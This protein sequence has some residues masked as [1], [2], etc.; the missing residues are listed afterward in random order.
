MRAVRLYAARDLRVEEI[1]APGV[2]APG[3]VRVRVTAAGICGSD[4][5]NFLTG[6]WISRVPSVAGHEFAGVVEA[7]GPGVSAL[8]PGDAVV[9]DS[10]F[11][12]GSCPACR[13]GRANVCERLGFVGEVCD[14]GFAE[15]VA[16]PERLLTLIAPTIDP[17]AAAL[18]EPLAVALHA[19][20]RLAPEPASPVLIAGCGPIGGLAALV[21]SRRH[22]GPVL[23]ADRN[24]ERL[25]R[26]VAVT[27]AHPVALDAEAVA[28]ARAGAPLLAALDA[29]GSS[30]VIETLAGLLAPGGRLALVG[31][32]RGS[33]EIDPTHLVEAE[34]A[35]LGCHA[36]RDE[37]AQAAALL[38]ALEAD[39]LALVD[40]TI[41][42]AEVPAAY[43]RLASGRASGLK[44]IILP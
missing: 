12:C 33:V 28:S 25:A 8:K 26:V 29:T 13:A 40:E 5:H 10:R 27:G 14:G 16:L 44:T 2:P 9:A 31:I 6:A 36:F 19:L 42:L 20:A 23:V 34:I 22:D 18:A 41:G 11:A 21:L 1:E 37:L 3:A 35:I 17:R 7:V 4:L 38:P 30:A 39:L 24:A 43:E 32:G 15:T